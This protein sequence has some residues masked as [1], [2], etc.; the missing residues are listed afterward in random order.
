M[1]IGFLSHLDANLYRFRLP[2]MQ[3]LLDNG[4]RVYA[5]VPRG[6]Y[7]E[8]LSREGI[9]TIIYEIE[10]SSLNPLKELV[11]INMIY[12]AIRDL[13]LDIL[14]TFMAK[15]NIYGTFAARKAKIP[16]VVNT[17][18]GLGSFF[19]DNSIKSKVIRK[20]IETLYKRVFNLSTGVIFQNRDDKELFERSG[21]IKKSKSYL[22]RS[23]GVDT[24]YFDSSTVNI[25][26]VKKLEDE[27]KV[28][29]KKVVLMIARAIWHKGISEYSKA[30]DILNRDNVEFLLVGGVDDG[31][32]SNASVSWLNEQKSI[33][34]LGERNDIKELIALSDIVVLPSYRE[35]VPRTLLEAASMEKALIATDVPGCREVVEHE[36]NGLLVELKSSKSLSDAIGKLLNDEKLQ[37]EYATASRK[38]AIEE[39]DVKKVVSSYSEIYSKLLN[40]QN[41][42]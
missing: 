11:A 22:V 20:V 8:E 35:G 39:F 23:S 16:V 32:P 17:V 33:S 37:D 10:R 36:K 6:E 41:P 14:H 2:V 29:E 18:T 3:A 42:D 13:N 30:A 1:T 27:L 34:W 12:R 24:T 40:V 5:I 19:I 31:N 28:K 21:I 15:P 25:E 38:K 7:T 4:H 9:T 26:D